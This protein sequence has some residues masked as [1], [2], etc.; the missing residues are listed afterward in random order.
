MA[1][2]RCLCVRACSCVCV[3]VCACSCVR[4]CAC[5]YMGVCVFMC[6]Y[7]YVRDNLDLKALYIIFSG[8]RMSLGCA[9]DYFT[10]L[11]WCVHVYVVHLRFYSLIL[12]LADSHIFVIYMC[13]DLCTHMWFNAMCVKI[14]VCVFCSWYLLIFCFCFACFSLLF[15]LPSFHPYCRF[16]SGNK[17]LTV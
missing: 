10:H 15:F 6:V 8:C 7:I 3:C 4:V 5:S 16:S 12:Y 9:Y 1:R 13:E 17:I 14:C 11:L 2:C